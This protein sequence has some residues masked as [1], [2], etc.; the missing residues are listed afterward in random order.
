MAEVIGVAASAVTL[1]ALFTNCIDCF[2]YFRAAQNCSAEAETLLVKLDCEKARLLVWANTVGILHTDYQ[3]RYPQLADPEREVL[4]RRCINQIIG[5]L[6]DA[7]KL[8][9]EYGGRPTAQ[10][11]SQRYVAVLSVNS[12]NIFKT[13]KRR[14][15]A[16][17]GGLNATPNWLSRIKWAIRDGAKFRIL[18]SHLKEFVDHIIELVPVPLDV[19]NSAVEE[20]ITTIIDIPTLRLAESACEESYPS[21]STRAS[22]VIKESEIGTLDRRNL[23]EIIRDI[24]EP[25]IAKEESRS[26]T[27]RNLT[28]KPTT[29][30]FLTR[31]NLG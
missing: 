14:F 12:M 19:I 20:D 10:R 23:E 15:F 29:W 21:W 4:I 25:D 31:T 26:N 6:T 24:D 9:A 11:E 8:Q 1:A 7:Q 13:T 18:L 17:A 28:S 16:R 27:K 2:S 3:G 5:L 22:E 30:K